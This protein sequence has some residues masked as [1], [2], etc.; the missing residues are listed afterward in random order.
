MAITYTPQFK[1]QD[2]IDNVDR[3]AAGGDNG[4]NARFHALEAEFTNL[5]KVVEDLSKAMRTAVPNDHSVT[6]KKLNITTHWDGLKQTLPADGTFE[7]LIPKVPIR[8]S[9]DPPFYPPLLLI[10]AYA[11]NDGAQFYWR[12]V[13]KTIGNQI[14]QVVTFENL[15]GKPIEII[16]KI[17]EL[18]ET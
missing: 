15:S 8:Y 12:V 6:V 13:S 18:I 2:W 3:V 7:C 4:F 14:Q 5:S 9:S 17:D 1:H 11:S 10:H 16:I